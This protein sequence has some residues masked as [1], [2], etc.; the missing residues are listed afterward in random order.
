MKIH[1]SNTET[2]HC[3]EDNKLFLK[4]QNYDVAKAYMQIQIFYIS[5]S[6]KPFS[7]LC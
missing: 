6:T 5:Q 4:N 7:S 2:I 1:L 3:K